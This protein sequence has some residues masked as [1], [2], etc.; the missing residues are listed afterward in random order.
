MPYQYDPERHLLR[1]KEW[2]IARLN[3][4]ITALNQEKTDGGAA[5]PQLQAIDPAAYFVQTLNGTVANYNP[6]VFIR[7]ADMSSQSDGPGVV[8]EM[9]IEVLLIVEDRGQDLLIGQRMLRY[10]RVLE[11]LFSAS[12]DRLF[13][14][15]TFKLN[16]LVPIALTRIDSNDPY[17]AVGVRLTVSVG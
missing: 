15:A 1:V 11:D 6:H 9:Q 17:R 3:T 8:K 13:P 14:H 10:L 2:L 16:S 12:F 7:L 4:Q 5:D